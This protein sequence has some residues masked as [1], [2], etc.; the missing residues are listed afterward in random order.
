MLFF[1]M[2]LPEIAKRFRSA[3]IV[4]VQKREDVLAGGDIKKV[5]EM[6]EKLLLMD[7]YLY[8][9]NQIAADVMEKF[10][11]EKTEKKGKE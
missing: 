2:V 11:D 7:E 4:L 8:N 6:D 9:A 1:I 5:L 10:K 3:R